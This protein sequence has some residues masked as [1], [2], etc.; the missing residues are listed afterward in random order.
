MNLLVRDSGFFEIWAQLAL[1][2]L[3]FAVTLA[4]SIV[5][6]RRIHR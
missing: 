1:L 4:V 3:F 6:L 5:V 2:L